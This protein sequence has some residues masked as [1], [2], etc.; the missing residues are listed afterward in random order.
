M[1]KNNHLFCQ[2]EIKHIENQWNENGKEYIGEVEIIGFFDLNKELIKEIMNIIKKE[3]VKKHQY[4]PPP[5]GGCLVYNGTRNDEGKIILKVSKAPEDNSKY[6]Q[7]SGGEIIR[8]G[9]LGVGASV[10]YGAAYVVGTLTAASVV[11]LRG[12]NGVLFG[13]FS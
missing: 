1:S 3:E 13:L 10:V 2:I 7:A 12:T 4:Y 8:K 6:L 5:S 9:I 11:I